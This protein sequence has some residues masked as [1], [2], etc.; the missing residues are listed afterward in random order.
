MKI[1][2]AWSTVLILIL[3]LFISN[4]VLAQNPFFKQFSISYENAGININQVIKDKNGFLW[5]AS[6]EGLYKYNGVDYVFYQLP[7]ENKSN[8]VKC[9]YEDA[10]G[11]IW[12][13]YKNGNIAQLKND[14]F[15]LLNAEEGLPRKDRKSVV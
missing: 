7:A 2:R 14:S 10:S 6:S 5:M 12:A 11:I 1:G 4:D 8:E 15:Q 3:F 13:G 9:V